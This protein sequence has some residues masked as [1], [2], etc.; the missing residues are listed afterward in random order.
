MGVGGWKVSY[1]CH[2]VKGLGLGEWK[3]RVKVGP[4]LKDI[5]ALIPRDVFRVSADQLYNLVSDPSCV[6]LELKVPTRRIGPAEV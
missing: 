2:G 6:V 5:V 4:S 3:V 1:D